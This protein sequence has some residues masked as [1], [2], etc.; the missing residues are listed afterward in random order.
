MSR[1][2]ARRNQ[3]RD[4]NA[5]RPDRARY[6][7]SKTTHPSTPR[8]RYLRTRIAAGAAML[9]TATGIAAGVP[10]YAASP[11]DGVLAWGQ[12]K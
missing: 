7:P 12:P 5:A 1:I 3:E 2:I 6:E 11:D 10:A 9:I 4:V 8:K